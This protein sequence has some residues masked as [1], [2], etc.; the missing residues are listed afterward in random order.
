MNNSFENIDRIYRNACESILQAFCEKYGQRFEKDAWV[1]EQHGTIAE[2]GMFFIDLQDMRYML[3]NN[4]QWNEFLHWY[5]YNLEIEEYGQHQVT[6][7]FWCN[8]FSIKAEKELD[9]L[10]KEKKNFDDEMEK[11][12]DFLY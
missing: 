9:M 10:R 4:I 1:G 3:A 7:E 6:L 2:V 11:V 5:D 8:G 12:K